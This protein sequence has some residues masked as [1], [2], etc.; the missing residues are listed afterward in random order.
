MRPVSARL[1]STVRGSHQMNARARVCST[2]Q[3]GTNPTGTEIRILGGDVQ[4]DGTADIRSTLD[5]ATEPALWP[6]GVD[7]LLAPYGN[8]IFVERGVEYGGGV[9]EWVS[10]GYFR[11]QAP[12]QANAPRGQVRVSG[13]D[14]M[15][16]LIDGR[17]T[18]PRQYLASA[19]YGTV[20]SA[21]VTDIYP[22]ATIEWDDSTDTQTLG[23]SVLAE[24]DRHA[25]LSDLIRS[26]GKIWYWDHRGVLVVKDA[27]DPAEPVFDVD[28]GAGGVLIALDHEL[29]R[30]SVYNG[31]IATGEAAD[32]APP[33]RAVAVDANPSSPTRWGG[34]F[35][36]VPRFYSSPFITTSTQALSAATALLKQSIG[37]P[38]SV[39]FT[40]VPNP[41]LEPYD[42][43]RIRY[44][45]GWRTHVLDKLT[46]PLIAA[47]AMTGATREQTI[48]VIGQD[49]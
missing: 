2:F 47:A 38:Y 9:T 7:D 6:A 16:G 13:R 18:S 43:V 5:M 34:K 30:D 25:F 8:E 27:P 26:V 31:V 14:R 28:A 20:V 33:A 3:T 23:R 24:E 45:G 40:M 44:D 15:A 35:G 46:V 12:G 49:T 32:T 4:L 11:I 39:D 10:L 42:P 19:T 37:L 17:L 21:L 48:I 41:G 36:K 29:S 22:G 1:L